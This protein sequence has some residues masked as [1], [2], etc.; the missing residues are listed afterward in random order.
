M[1]R[2]NVSERRIW[3]VSRLEHLFFRNLNSGES[4]PLASAEPL[5]FDNARHQVLQALAAGQVIAKYDC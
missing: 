2:G 4:P 1:F 5:A 3:L